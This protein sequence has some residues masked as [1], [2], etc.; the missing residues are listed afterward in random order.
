[1]APLG[2]DDVT[3]TSPIIR[4][5]RDQDQGHPSW[6]PG[7]SG[8]RLGS[9]G[10]GRSSFSNKGINQCTLLSVFPG[11]CARAGDPG[12]SG[13]DSR[14]GNGGVSSRPSPEPSGGPSGTP[15][16]CQGLLDTI[17][18]YYSSHLYHRRAAE[19]L[20]AGRTAHPEKHTFS[21]KFL[22]KEMSWH[23]PPSL[24][25]GVCQSSRVGLLCV[26][27]DPQGPASK[28]KAP[29]PPPPLELRVTPRRELRQG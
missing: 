19:T 28:S 29:L 20:F 8:P 25:V 27:A 4:V 10:R 18:L 5:R 21:F 3:P 1:M 14:D 11:R 26:W 2:T 9:P 16:L 17:S 12:G 15:R 22:E 23:L 6:D 13:G 24:E 7:P